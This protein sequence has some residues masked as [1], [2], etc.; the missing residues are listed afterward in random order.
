MSTLVEINS[1]SYPDEDACVFGTVERIDSAV[2][3]NDFF[4]KHL[5]CN[6]PCVIGL[7]ATENWP[8]RREWVL[9]GAPNFEVLRTLFGMCKIR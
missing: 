2:T 5:I 3:Y 7:Q 6:K 8:C 1:S 9:R 4:Y